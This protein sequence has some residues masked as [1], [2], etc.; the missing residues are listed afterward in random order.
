M[1]MGLQFS[2]FHLG[3]VW[4][5][6]VAG[7]VQA[8]SVPVEEETCVSLHLHWQHLQH[9]CMPTPFLEITQNMIQMNTI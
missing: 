9:T 7:I 4:G 5:G 2:D 6:P 8:S 3:V 1:E